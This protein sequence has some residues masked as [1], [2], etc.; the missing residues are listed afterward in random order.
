MAETVIRVENV[1]RT[2]R[3]GDVDVQALRGVSLTV[4]RGEFVAIMGS[5]GS[6]KSTLMSIVG[7]LDRPS[8][9]RYFFEGIDIAGFSTRHRGLA[10]ARAALALL[11]LGDRERN[12]PGQLSGGQQQRVA[13]ARALINAPSV[14]LADE[15]TGNLD[16]RTSH[17]IMGTLQSLNREQGVTIVVVTH[18]PDIAAYADRTVTMRD[19]QIISDECAR[20]A[21]PLQRMV[22]TLGSADMLSFHP[23]ATGGSAAAPTAASWARGGGAGDLPQ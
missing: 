14:L 5:S 10:R 3:V 9:G 17:E 1:T 18:E 12:S 22:P 16:T 23:R 11:G 4:D 7:C 2:Y 21:S 13:I 20:A 8:S 6:G 19:G 15:P